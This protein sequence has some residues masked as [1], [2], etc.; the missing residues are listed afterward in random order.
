MEDELV[1][2]ISD[3]P[4]EDSSDQKRQLQ[5]PWRDLLFKPEIHRSITDQGFEYPRKV[6]EE[7]FPQTMLGRDLFCKSNG[8]TGKTLI[9][10][11]SILQQLD[12]A[13]PGIQAL[14]LC[15]SREIAQQTRYAFEWSARF[16]PG[17]KIA[18]VIGG[19]GNSVDR[20]TFRNLPHV[21]IG[22]LGRIKQCA[23]SKIFWLRHLKFFVIDDADLVLGASGMIH[24]HHHLI[25]LRPSEGCFELEEDG[26]K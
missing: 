19:V 22:T 11:A 15:H 21:V 18:L 6:Q 10:I 8:G 7:C 25:D 5:V 16:L 4:M 9:Y 23:E 24:D 26:T 1:D 17:V 13:A 20:Q 12:I 2:Y 3:D 14:I